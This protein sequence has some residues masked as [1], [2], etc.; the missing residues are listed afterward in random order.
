MK[1]AEFF[2]HSAGVNRVEFEAVCALF[3]A[4]GTPQQQRLE[5]LNRIAIHPMTLLAGDE[6][7]K[8]PGGE[9]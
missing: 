4:E 7:M 1:N 3:I 5:R 9:K 2:I 6:R 8:L